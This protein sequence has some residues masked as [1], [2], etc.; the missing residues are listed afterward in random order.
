MEEYL[1][2]L[3]VLWQVEGSAIGSR[4]IIGLANI[5]WVVVEGG[6]PGVANVL[7]DLVAIAIQL[8]ESWYGEV[9]PFRIVELQAVEI[10]GCILMVFHKIESPHALHREESGRL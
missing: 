2:T 6:T 9:Y 3:P 1:L 8:K 7:I 5:G 10:L 4:V